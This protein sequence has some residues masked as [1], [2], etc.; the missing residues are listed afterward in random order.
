MTI[1]TPRYSSEDVLNSLGIEVNSFEELYMQKVAQE[2]I[3]NY[4]RASF[5]HIFRYQG[6]GNTHYVKNKK[7]KIIDNSLLIVNRDILQRYSKHKCRGD[8]VLFNFNFFTSTQEKT[9]FLNQCTLFK[10]D[11]LIIP[12]GPGSFISSI[13][14]YFSLMKMSIKKKK[15]R[16]VDMVLLRNWLHN[17]LIIIEREYHRLDP[18]RNSKDCILEFKGLLDLYYQREKHVCFYAKKLNISERKLSQ[19]VYAVHSISAKEY[20]NEKIL[21]EALRLLKNTTLN[22]GEIAA[23]LGLDFTYFVKFFRKRFNITPAKYRQS[24]R[25][26]II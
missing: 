5:Y 4:H 8:M 16:E 23:A 2:M 26:T 18:I 12:P 22:Q 25:N 10:N 11:Y 17:L 19:I 21:Q 20:I 6:E 9:N 13:D 14:L 24:K 7:I 1:K 3:Y 15:I